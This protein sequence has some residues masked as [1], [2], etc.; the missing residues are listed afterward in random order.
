MRRG[1]LPGVLTLGSLVLSLST[2]RFVEST[3]TVGNDLLPLSILR[4]HS[5]TFDQYN[6]P[7]GADREYP[8]GQAAVLADAIPPERA[9]RVAP[10]VPSKSLPWWFQRINGHVVSLYPIAPGV[11]NT[12]AFFIADLLHLDLADSVVPLTHLTRQCFRRC[13]SWRCTLPDP[14]V[15]P[16]ARG[17]DVEP[18][19]IGTHHERLWDVANGESARCPARRRKR[20]L[21][22][23]GSGRGAEVAQSE[24]SETSRA[25]SKLEPLRPQVMQVCG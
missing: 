17:F 9:Y 7:P 12:P 20:S 24:G 2:G 4:Q 21:T 11:L 6:A 15:S 10:E 14:G 22:R 18:N 25:C 13:S 8:T 23:P 19:D 3:D 1:G 5:L 16:A